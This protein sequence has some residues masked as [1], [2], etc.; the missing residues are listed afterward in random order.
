MRLDYHSL[1][2]DGLEDHVGA[3]ACDDAGSPHVRRVHD[4]EVN[5]HAHV[6]FA[7]SVFSLFLPLPAIWINHAELTKC[8]QLDGWK[9]REGRSTLRLFF[10]SSSLLSPFLRRRVCNEKKN[11]SSG[12]L[13]GNSNLRRNRFLTSALL[14]VLQGRRHPFS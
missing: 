9:L 4:G 10:L 14:R 11:T 5:H 3:S 7:F 2:Q 12:G 1:L 6:V 8:W 13:Q